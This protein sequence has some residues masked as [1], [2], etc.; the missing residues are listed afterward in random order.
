MTTPMQPA[1]FGGVV[2][3]WSSLCSLRAGLGVAR[4]VEPADLAAL[5]AVIASCPQP[6]RVLGRGTNIVG[7]DDDGLVALRLPARGDFA[8][9]TPLGDGRFEVGAGLSLTRLL[10]ILAKEGFGG[11]AALSGIPGTLGGALAMNAGALGQ[12]IAAN[13]LAMLGFDCRTGRKWLWAEGAG[14]WGYRTSPVP[15]EVVVTRATLHFARVEAAEELARIS[16]ERVRRQKVTPAGFSAGSV[17]RN[18]APELPA[19]RLLEQ[20]GCKGM[21]ESVFAVSAEHAN[22]IVNGSG[23]PG[24][25]ADCRRLADRMAAAVGRNAGV[26]LHGEWRWMA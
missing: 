20:A 10:A 12:E 26:T 3:P 18:P 5:L 13:V 11:G 23:D 9:I 22:W 14:G 4:V 24:A 21:R 15:P 6:P 17:F 25:A 7:S 2:R 8:A 1:S 16:A 19:G